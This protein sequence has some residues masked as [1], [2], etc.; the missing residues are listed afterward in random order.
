MAVYKP[1]VNILLLF[2]I[3]GL[4]HALD[5]M[6]VLLLGFSHPVKSLCRL[7]TWEALSLKL[8][9]P[10]KGHMTLLAGFEDTIKA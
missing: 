5:L 9:F 3:G 2:Q 6:G 1:D 4:L 7:P 8:S 10:L